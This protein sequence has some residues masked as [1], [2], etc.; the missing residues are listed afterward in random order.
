MTALLGQ[1]YQDRLGEDTCWPH[2][3]DPTNVLVASCTPAPIQPILIEA[4][5]SV[6]QH[7]QGS[8]PKNKLTYNDVAIED[9]LALCT[10]NQFLRDTTEYMRS[11]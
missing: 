3:Q 2:L 9:S 8:S 11:R 6:R 10:R 7:I 5:R 4:L 1:G